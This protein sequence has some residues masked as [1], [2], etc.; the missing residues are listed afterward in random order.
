LLG[1]FFVIF[2]YFLL[3]YELIYMILHYHNPSCQWSD[4][5]LNI[6]YLRQQ[7]LSPFFFFSIFDFTYR[8]FPSFLTHHCS[9]L[10]DECD[11]TSYSFFWFALVFFSYFL[12]LGAECFFYLLSHTVFLWIYI[13]AFVLLA[14]SVF[15]HFFPFS[16][17]QFSWWL[18]FWRKL[19]ID[20]F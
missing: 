7:I 5:T 6:Y 4:L 9:S 13:E 10:F 19:L 1:I 3:F 20:C 14:F 2:V 16:T 12:D 8:C 11:A 17:K 18:S 15:L